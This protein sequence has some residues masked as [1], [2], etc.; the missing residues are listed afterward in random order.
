MRR[1]N[2]IFIVRGDVLFRMLSKVNLAKILLCRLSQLW[3]NRLTSDVLIQKTWPQAFAVWHVALVRIWMMM[4]IA[5]VL[6]L[7]L[8]QRMLL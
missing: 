7:K 8:V 5:L 6:M 3:V 1:G 4:L 2:Q